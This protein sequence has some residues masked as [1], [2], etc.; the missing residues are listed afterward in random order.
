MSDRS[1]NLKLKT[2]IEFE[3][4]WVRLIENLFCRMDV[5]YVNWYE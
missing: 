4:N 3:L 2:E 5:L 1:G